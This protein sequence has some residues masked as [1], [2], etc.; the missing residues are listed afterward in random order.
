MSFK[1]IEI[2]EG[3]EIDLKLYKYLLEYFSD[4]ELRLMFKY[5]KKPPHRYY[6]RVNTLKISTEEL[7]ER[8]RSR[9]LYAHFDEYLSEAI[10]FRIEGPFKIPSARRIVI[11][12][13]FAAESIYI[14]ANLYF[15][16]IVRCEDVR[17]GDEVNIMAPNGEVIAYGIAEEDLSSTSLKNRKGLAVRVI[18]S[19]YKA[20]K[21]RE[22]PEYINGLIYDQSLPAQ[23]TSHILNPEEGEL[24]ID[25]CASPGGKLSHIVQLCKGRARIYAFDRSSRKILQVLDTLR[26]LDMI[27]HVEVRIADSRY[28]DIDY[29]ELVGKVDKILLDP[30]CTSIGVRPK[31]FDR[32]CMSQVKAASNYQRQFISTACKLLRRGGILVYSTC[33]LT[34]MENEDIVNYALR[35]GFDVEYV[36]VPSKSYG[37]YYP[38]SFMLARF[39]PHIQDTPGFFIA[40][41]VKK[42]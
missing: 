18:K 39:Y 36:D 9:K 32:K 38:W 24:I 12:D 22:L 29:P 15:P 13:K 27:N 16:G 21:I 25:M 6:V 37:L 14:G 1:F 26:R 33:T 34:P 8:L 20:P 10:W 11:V 19:I 31:L 7:V 35:I 28:L 3:L 42:G 40:K 5:I 17:K 30:S 23:W 41:L 2:V 4:S